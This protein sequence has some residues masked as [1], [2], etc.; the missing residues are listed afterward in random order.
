[1]EAF[2]TN[3]FETI[4]K[5]K[6]QWQ[7][8]SNPDPWSKAEP[9]QWKSYTLEHSYLIEKA[10]YDQQKEV[11][12]GDYIVYL[13]D[14]LQWKK[15]DPKAQRP[16]RRINC[17]DDEEMND[18][19]TRYFE[20]E[21]PKTINKIFGGLEDFI[22]FFSRRNQEILEFRNQFKEFEESND[23]NILNQK[24]IPILI[25]CFKK[26]LLKPNSE[27]LQEGPLSVFKKKALLR[28]KERI[29]ELISLF[30]KEFLSPEE[31]YGRIFRAYTMDTDLYPILN[32]YL[33]NEN[34]VEVD[35]L[36]SYA[37]CLCKSFFNL[38]PQANSA[39]GDQIGE[40]KTPSSILLYR[41]TAFDE[42]ALSF[43]NREKV[44]YFSW[45]SVTSTSKSK[46]TA[47]DFMYKTADIANKKYPVMFLIEVPLASE[48]EPEYLKWVDI[49]QY[50]AIPKEDEVVLP[51][52]SVFELAEVSTNQDKIS[53]IK[54]KLRNEIKSLAHGGMMMQGAL[55][56]QL[57]TEKEAKVT[58][59]ERE[60]LHQALMS[61]GGNKLIEEVEF[62]LCTFDKKL[63]NKMFEILPTLQ[64]V[65]TL[66]FIACNSEDNEKMIQEGERCGVIKIEVIEAS[67]FFQMIYNE[68]RDQKYWVALR[69]L[70]ID[71]RSR[72][73]LK[74]E[75][76]DDEVSQR[77][78]YFNQ[79]TSLSIN[80]EQCSQITDKGAKSLA[81]CLNYLTKLTNLNL[82]FDQCTKITDKG[83][84]S[85]AQSL[86]SLTQLVHLNI[87][88][89]EC[90]R[91]TDEGVNSLAQNLNSLTQLTHLNLNFQGCY[92][93]TDGI[94]KSLAKAINSLTHLISLNI[95]FSQCGR[96]TG[97]GVD[98]SASEGLKF[99]SLLKS[100]NL[101]FSW[102]ENARPLSQGLRHITQLT[103]LTLSNLYYDDEE[104]DIFVSDGLKYL[105]QLTSLTLRLSKYQ[106]KE[107]A[108]KGLEI[109]ASQGLKSL[110]SLTSLDLEFYRCN[111]ITDRGVDSLASKG[112]KHLLQLKSLALE[113]NDCRELTEEGVSSLMSQGLKN[114]TQLTSLILD[115]TDCNAITDKGMETLAAK[116]LR[117]LTIFESLTVRCQRLKNNDIQTQQQ[118]KSFRRVKLARES[119]QKYKQ[120]L[121]GELS[122]SLLDNRNSKMAS[123]STESFKQCENISSQDLLTKL[124]PV[125]NK[126]DDRTH[127]PYPSQND[128]EIF[129]QIHHLTS[130]TL[131]FQDNWNIITDEFVHNL[132]S[133]VLRNIPQLK[134][135]V[136]NLYNCNQITDGGVGSLALYGLKSLTVLESLTLDLGVFFPSSG[137]TD[138]GILDLASEGLRHL[139]QLKSLNLRFWYR[140]HLTDKGVDDFALYGLKSLINL[141]SLNLDFTSCSKITDEGVL[142]LASGGL[143][144]LSQLKSL[145][146]SF[147]GCRQITD[148]GVGD[149]SLY[150]L[151]SLVNLASFNLR[152]SSCSEITD[153][154]MVVLASE[155]LRHLFQLKSLDLNF[156]GCERITDEGWTSLAWNGLRHLSQLE[157][158]VLLPNSQITDTAVSNL[159]SQGLKPLTNLASLNL[160]FSCSKQI[161]DKGMMILASEGLRNLF[162]L[163]S[164]QLNFPGCDQISAEGWTHLAWNGLR[165]LPQLESFVLDPCREI[166]DEGV[167]SLVSQGLKYLT[168]LKSL[169]I[170]FFVS[171]LTDKGVNHLIL[172][173]IKNLPKLTSLD[174][175]FTG[176]RNI[177]DFTIQNIIKVLCYFGFTKEI[178][179]N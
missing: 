110:T 124:I 34:W 33:R 37:L 163:K 157:S 39:P 63:L 5:G 131:D 161:T 88:L 66:K 97:K 57:M 142:D 75:E 15:G 61:L 154:G 152:F 70:D 3:D 16:I 14:L 76:L 138:K 125:L 119:S 62:C 46:T 71:F 56:S 32:N 74:D 115:F 7:W 158:F 65:K 127:D 54:V 84:D 27:Q 58:C 179:S 30:Q 10:Y 93:I 103:S 31:F 141:A 83:M 44:Q 41:G 145:K 81:K 99:L 43:Y 77:L 132:A 86:N 159:A 146:L 109:L 98:T 176:A 11:D 35:K 9:P 55:Q 121:D 169:T 49:H 102:V 53:I 60:E 59:L 104:I 72:R 168:Q 148:K 173:I 95:N 113:F 111:E 48:C 160:N 12:L 73:S 52:G 140:S 79:L 67:N 165:H 20:T 139:S 171:H 178:V 172:Q 85:L 112:L 22:T 166:T 92:Q 155:G 134:S 107:I 51:P 18:R 1:M 100:L 147:S 118:F 47:E 68:K 150:G 151:K 89:K 174:L 130:L 136:L 129:S 177:S 17:L 170:S 91:I 24:I 69:E 156:T 78:K 4:T 167:D 116:W 128:L 117:N 144:H 42:F 29:E 96:T 126:T 94:A 162:R 50:S 6:W 2:T 153:K 135:L 123:D 122:A 8:K 120:S 108:D 114:L 38:T 149:L 106:F 143:R 45:N 175:N 82:N 19:S 90:T 25:D 26:V 80:F 87:N 13:L 133:Q 23:F 40:F 105:V 64:R 164:L 21:L 36:L 101:G 137:I 28:M